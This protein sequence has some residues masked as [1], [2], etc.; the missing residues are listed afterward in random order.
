MARLS[1]VDVDKEIIRRASTGAVPRLAQLFDVSQSYVEKIRNGSRG[2]PAP[3]GLGM[4]PWLLRSKALIDQ[5]HQNRLEQIERA[6]Q[7]ALQ[8]LDRDEALA[9]APGEPGSLVLFRG[10]LALKPAAPPVTPTVPMPAKSQAG[11]FYDRRGTR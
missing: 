2:F 7:R 6:Y 9:L 4:R 1:D 3:C 8:S 10:A 5:W 11:V